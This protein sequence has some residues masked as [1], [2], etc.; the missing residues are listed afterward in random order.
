[1]LVDLLAEDVAHERLLRSL[2]GR[3]AR[4]AHINVDIRVRAARGGRPRVMEELELYQRSIARGVASRPSL[5]IVAIDS[6]CTPYVRARG[7][8]ERRIQPA[9]RD[10]TLIA[11]PDPHV[12]RW[13]VAD[14]VSFAQAVGRQPRLG[15]R[16]CD[17]DRYKRILAEAVSSAGHPVLLGGI[18]FADELIEHMDLYRAGKNEKSFKRFIDDLR[19]RLGPRHGPPC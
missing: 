12:E 18:E 10:I 4:E 17:R 2:I 7:Q 19:S 16:K 13:Y 1:V 5:L 11:C 9:F 3:L 8:I 14:P 6:N 15:K